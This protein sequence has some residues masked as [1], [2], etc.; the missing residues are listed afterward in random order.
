LGQPVIDT[1]LSFFSEHGLE[2]T[3][4]FSLGMVFFIGAL[5][6]IPRPPICV[7][8]GLIFGLT[9]FPV[10]LAGSTFGA[11]LAFLLSRYLFRSRF[12]G[13]IERRPRLKLIVEAIDAEGWRL[14]GLLRLASPVPGS[15]SNYLFGLT[16]MRIWPYMAATL[17]GSAPQVLAFVYLGTA[18]RIALNAQSIS[19]ANLVFT[20]A[21]GALSLCAIVLVTRR[22]KSMV[23]IKLACQTGSR[24]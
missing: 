10:A 7:I 11:V 8:G 13:L 21:G 17:L 24:I 5:T 9:A 19:V 12:S 20:L 16:N 3:G 14:L 22:V 23:A 1:F 15:A 18:G 4:L 2:K 6:F